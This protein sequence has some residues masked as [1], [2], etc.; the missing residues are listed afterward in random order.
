MMVYE[1]SPLVGR[2]GQ[3]NI[4]EGA[5]VAVLGAS[6][7]IGR[8]VARALCRHGADVY[9]I[10]R[11]KPAAEDIFRHYDVT[12]TICEA[13]L[14]DFKLLRALFQEIR[15]SITFNLASYGVDPFET[16]IEDLE[17]INRRLVKAVCQAIW[18]T[19]D[20]KWPGQQIVHAGSAL[21]YG[22]ISGNL[23][24]NSEPNPTTPYG[25]S[26]LAGTRS[27]TWG[28]AVYQIKGLT[29]R[30]FTVYGPGEHARRLLP[31]LIESARTGKPLE[32]TAG[33]QRRDFTYVEDVAA[34]LLRLGL[35]APSIGGIVNLATGHLTSVR[36]FVEAA[37]VKLQIPPENLKFGLLATRAEEMDHAEVAVGRLLQWTAWIPTTSIDE[38]IGKTLEFE[39]TNNCRRIEDELA[40]ASWRAHL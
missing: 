24:E 7:F 1:T 5:R 6:G 15:P 40:H 25:R 21:E 31:S 32:L 17:L 19:R 16:D 3:G 4:Y 11:N 10:V 14:C 26:K 8:W 36:E 37:A 35:A 20:P 30:L 22:A 38:G 29:A 39:R 12:G 34:G 2:N 33:K 28:C 13:D 9:L 23:A 18:D 27:L